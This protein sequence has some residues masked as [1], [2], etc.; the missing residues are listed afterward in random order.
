MC[1]PTRGGYLLDMRVVDPVGGGSYFEKR[2]RRYNEPGQPRELTFSCYR[3]M[4]FF[5][6][7]RTCEWFRQA[8]EAA[9]QSSAFKFGPTCSCRS[10]SPFGPSGEAAG[11]CRAF[12]SRERAGGATGDWLLEGERA[13]WLPG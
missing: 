2:R 12:R 3:R 13:Q 5:S 8:L 4:P 9:L 11:K 10:R 6:R 1:G 7:E